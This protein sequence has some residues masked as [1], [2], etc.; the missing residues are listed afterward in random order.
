MRY[1]ISK[2]V[3]MVLDTKPGMK[4]KSPGLHI[5]LVSH[6]AIMLE[7]SDV[8]VLF[9]YLSSMNGLSHSP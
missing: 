3:A 2:I 9:Y 7:D 8:A 6:Q 4:M 5:M 1:Q